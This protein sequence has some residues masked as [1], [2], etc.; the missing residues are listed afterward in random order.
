MNISL[1]GIAICCLVCW[2]C[3]E[4]G[5]FWVSE[6]KASLFAAFLLLANI[7]AYNPSE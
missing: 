7:E 4:D 3:S 5:I 1:M 2:S 6:M